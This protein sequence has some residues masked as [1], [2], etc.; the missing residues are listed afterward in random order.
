MNLP[1][2]TNKSKVAYRIG[3]TIAE[4][5]KKDN[6]RYYELLEPVSISVH[7][8]GAGGINW[9]NDTLTIDS[10]DKDTV[11]FTV[12]PFAAETHYWNGPS[13]VRDIDDG[14]IEASLVHDLIWEWAG[15]I[16]SANNVKVDDLIRWSNLH[17]AVL[18][19]AYG[20]EKGCNALALRVKTWLAA[21]VCSS[22]L[23]RLWKRLIVVIVLASLGY[24]TGCVAIPEWTSD[25]PTLNYTPPTTETL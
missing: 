10:P 14:R 25:T 8:P 21:N 11:T 23:A 4:Y 19:R 24:T 1:A 9:S 20:K 15:E 12:Q 17:L 2:I 6:L 7:G 3:S 13:V 22:F 5:L 18:W 16:A